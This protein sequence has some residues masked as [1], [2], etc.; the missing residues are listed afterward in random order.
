LTT[1]TLDEAAL[2]ESRAFNQQLARLLAEQT[3]VHLLPAEVTRRVRREGRGIWPAPV[4]LPQAR[5]VTIPT[6]GGEIRLRV[7]APEDGSAGV[8]LHLHGGGWV[9]GE[10]DEQDLRLWA[11]AE[12]TGLCVVS[13]GYRLAPEHPYPA[14]LDDCEDAATWLLGGG[15]AELGLPDRLMVAGESAGANLA[16]AMLVRLRD[17][18]GATGAFRAANLVYGGYDLAKKA[19]DRD[20]DSNLVLTPEVRR[21]FR[22]CY[23][24][25]RSPEEL[26]D[27]DISPL[28]ADLRDLPPALFTVGELDPLLDDSVAMAARWEAAGNGAEL[29]VWPESVHGFNLFP[30]ALA[31]AANEAQ[32]EFLRAAVAD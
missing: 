10:C 9:L 32:Y 8:Y 3:S 27:P 6:R 11:L 20:R 5:D 25:D 17:R 14:G 29:T 19:S 16:V 7:L 12:A 28:Y 30:L 2:A 15:L 13:V 26:R 22:T 23:A 4:F 31:R 24:G 21:W 18:H 1:T